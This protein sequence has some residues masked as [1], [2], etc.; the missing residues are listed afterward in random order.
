MNGNGHYPIFKKITYLT[1]GVVALMITVYLASPLFISTEINEQFP[2]NSASSISFDKY[3]KMGEDER[4]RA[5]EN[6]SNSQ[7]NQLM[8]Q[9]ANSS[10]DSSNNKIDESINKTVTSFDPNQLLISG[11][12]TGVN[13]GIHNA[14]GIAKIIPL[15]DDT[16]VLRLENLKVTN[17]PDLY[18]YLSTDNNALDFVNL[19]KLKA[20]NGNQNYDIPLGTDLSK[21]DTALIWCK[22]FSVLFG[23]A[24][25]KVQ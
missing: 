9:Y 15:Q 16:N 25:L 22:A 13:D 21:Y 10:N 11:V 6:M 12:F 7:K 3:I 17:G 14:E 20:N 5:A 4:V 19:G 24:E 8:I 2:T 1:I 18:V 23:S